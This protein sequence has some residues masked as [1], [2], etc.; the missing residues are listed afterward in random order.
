MNLCRR[1]QLERNELDVVHLLAHTLAGNADAIAGDRA[2]PVQITT[3]KRMKI[4]NK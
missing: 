4:T 3:G 1:I 2:K